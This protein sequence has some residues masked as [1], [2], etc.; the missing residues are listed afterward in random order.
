MQAVAVAGDSFGDRQAVEVL[1]RS[2]D[3]P[4]P[5]QF[6]QSR[7]RELGDVVVG[8]AER[9][10]QLPA[11]IAG[12][13][14]PAAVDPE[15]FEDRDPQGVG[16]RPGQ[17]LPVDR[18]RAVSHVPILRGFRSRIAVYRGTVGGMSV[19]GWHAR[20]LPKIIDSSH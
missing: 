6:D 12:G 1:G 13:E 7:F 3:L 11:E 5:H 2:A 19:L 9:D 14:D 4:L 18:N 20:I 16:G 10:L 17:P 8:V 15:D